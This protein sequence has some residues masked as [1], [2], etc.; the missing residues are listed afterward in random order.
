MLDLANCF[1]GAIISEHNWRMASMCQ[2]NSL[3]VMGVIPP[4]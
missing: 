3:S 4:Y 1:D 2:I